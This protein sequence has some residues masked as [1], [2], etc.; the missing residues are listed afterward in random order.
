MFSTGQDSFVCDE[1]YLDTYRSFWWAASFK[2]AS[3][4][5]SMQLYSCYVSRGY[6]YEHIQFIAWIHNYKHKH[7]FLFYVTPFFSS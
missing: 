7:L 3:V 1:G 2:V 5:P 6:A 4:G